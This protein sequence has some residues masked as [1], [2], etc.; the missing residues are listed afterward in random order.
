[1]KKNIK[2]LIAC[3]IVF[4]IPTIFT[5]NVKADDKIYYDD[6]S[7]ELHGHIVQKYKF[8][9]DDDSYTSDDFYFDGYVTDSYGNTYYNDDINIVL[10]YYY[11]NSLYVR[12]V[13]KIPN[14]NLVQRFDDYVEQL[15]YVDFT[16]D[17]TLEV[18]N[19][20]C[21]M[22]GRTL[23]IPKKY[24]SLK[25]IN[26]RSLNS[27]IVEFDDDINIKKLDVG[28]HKLTIHI[29]EC[30][31]N[32]EYNQASTEITVKVISKVKI[33]TTKNSITIINKTDRNYEYSLNSKEWST[34]GIFTD[35]KKNKK[36]TLYI[37]ESGSANEYVS[38]RITIRLK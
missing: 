12:G 30:S 8:F 11:A 15:Q 28:T 16:P 25:D 32:K 7:L 36:Y 35:L 5:N 19:E 1:M 24:I 38:A 3:L 22:Q 37:R 6:R 10:D 18:T 20:F 31:D 21:V 17:T 26:G 33:T 13:I 4:M 23:T 34:D 27:Y 2:V 29:S 14:T 9:Y